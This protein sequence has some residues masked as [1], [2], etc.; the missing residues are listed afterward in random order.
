M[1]AVIRTGGKQYRVAKNDVISVEKIDGDEGATV[2]FNEVLMV[3]GDGAAKVGAPLIAGAQV[4]GTVLDQGKDDKII[5]FKKK[6]R[7]N[8]RRKRGHRQER[9]VV[10]IGEITAG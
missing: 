4:T 3:G 5:I 10:R 7:Q 8:Y 1:Y 6:R 9:T 2:A